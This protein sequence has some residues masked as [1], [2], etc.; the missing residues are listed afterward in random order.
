MQIATSIWGAMGGI[1]ISNSL[2]A[3]FAALGL[4]EGWPQGIVLAGILL[5]AVGAA[6]AL[7]P[8]RRP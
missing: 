7:A 6:L 2:T 1:E 5:A 8:V 4:L 3:A